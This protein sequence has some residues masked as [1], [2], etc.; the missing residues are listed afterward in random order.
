M[1]G[2]WVV[3]SILA[4]GVLG[5]ALTAKIVLYYIEESK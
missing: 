3:M 2:E 4:L 1:N 5:I